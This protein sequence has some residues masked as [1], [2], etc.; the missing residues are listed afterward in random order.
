MAK[1]IKAWKIRLVLVSKLALATIPILAWPKPV[2]E[3]PPHFS[4]PFSGKA[5]V[6]RPEGRYSWRLLS[7]Q[8]VLTRDKIS[9]STDIYLPQNRTPTELILIRT[10]YDKDAF[11][12]D[13][14]VQ[15]TVATFV[16]HGYAVAVQDV[17]GKFDSEGVFAPTSHDDVDS[18]DTMDWIVRQ[19]WSNGKIGTFGC[20][21]LGENQVT[22]ARLKHA[23]WRAAIPI[24][25]AGASGGAGGRYR[26]FAFWNGGAFELAMGLSWF[27]SHGRKVPQRI[28]GPPN[29]TGR[30]WP[31]MLTLP[32][33]AALNDKAIPDNDFLSFISNSPKSP[34]WD[35]FPYLRDGDEIAVPALFI[36]S[37]YDYGP[38]DVFSQLKHFQS[39]SGDLGDDHRIVIDP[40]THCMQHSLSGS[41]LVGHR[42]LGDAR[43]DYWKLY[44]NW[45]DHWLRGVNNGINEMPVVQYYQMGL[46]RWRTS[47][48]WPVSNTRFTK[49]YL[50][51]TRGARS[52]KGD[53][54]LKSDAPSK[55][56]RDTF[57]YNP[58]NPVPTR[59]G[60][61][62]CVPVEDGKS[63]EGAYDQ[64]DI[65]LRED[66][67]VYSTAP[68]KKSI[69]VTGPVK[70]VLFVSSDM[71][72]TDF[73]AK[74]V[75]VYPD[76][77]A[78]NIVDGITRMRWRKGYDREHFLQPGRVYKVEI[79]LQAT[80]NVFLKGH[81]IRLEVSSSNFPRFDRNLNTG[82]ANFDEKE[83][84]IATNSVHYSPKYTSHLV[85]PVVYDE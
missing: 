77:R 39:H 8:A 31:L 45:F 48:S 19:P 84:R 18:Y 2:A 67:L 11:H 53:G 43:F 74:L 61:T 12:P 56:G 44:L 5:P 20:S 80:S 81:Q 3:R 51:S 13:N 78:F 49:F 37:W 62:C 52:R 22:A 27:T 42:N 26:Q 7:S 72:D 16:T 59:G 63:A 85:L 83:G 75:D 35:Q 10:P 41:T 24:A 70:A 40:T 32:V 9:L 64:S 15:G 28:E 65:Q 38:A 58:L 73:T 6:A 46:N 69:D 36:E 57:L 66:V 68:L 60:P 1:S 17:R 29:Y 25:S 71:P 30:F 14:S 33:A 34:Y 4:G 54:V 21:Y 82:G 55:P 79:D 47:E 50:A 23:A 76:G